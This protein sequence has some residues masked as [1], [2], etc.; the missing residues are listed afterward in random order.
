MQAVIPAMTSR[1]GGAIVNIA[2]TAGLQ[3]IAGLAAY[4]STKFAIRGLTKTAAIELGPLGI[5]VNAICPGGIDTAMGRGDDFASVDT[6]NFFKGM[7]IPRIGK[8]DEVARAC[9]FLACDDASYCTGTE[10]VVDGGMLAG[11]AWGQ[12]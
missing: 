1:G 3:G 5:R 12:E 9:V 8:P 6:S 2:S 4:V 7:P 10:L 11:P